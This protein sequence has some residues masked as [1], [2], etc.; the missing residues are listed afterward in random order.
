VGVKNVCWEGLKW[1]IWG[2]GWSRCIKKKIRNAC[3]IACT[4][5]LETWGASDVEG[6]L[7]VVEMGGWEVK[8]V[9]EG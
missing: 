5:V 2:C 4:C 8:H 7:W 1:L 9:M 6:R 3:M